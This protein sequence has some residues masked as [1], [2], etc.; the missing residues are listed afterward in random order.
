M[1]WQDL[2]D[3]IAFDVSEDMSESLVHKLSMPND[4][5][6]SDSNSS[7]SNSDWYCSASTKRGKFEWFCE[8]CLSFQ[9][10]RRSYDSS[11]ESEPVEKNVCLNCGIGTFL[12]EVNISVN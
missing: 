1:V 5:N 3:E 6:S 12:V 7:D 2:C 10:K 8:L 11:Y 9:P 4:S